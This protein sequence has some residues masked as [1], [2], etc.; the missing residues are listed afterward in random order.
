VYLCYLIGFQLLQVRLIGKI[1]SQGYGWNAAVIYGHQWWRLITPMFLHF[2]FQHVLFNCFSIFLFAPVLEMMLGKWKFSIAYFGSGII[3][4]VLALYFGGVGQL[5]YL[6]ASAAIFGL[7]GIF[8][9]IIIF[10][11]NLMDRQSKQIVAIILI[12]NVAWTFIFPSVDVLGHLFG[13][14]GGFLLGPFLVMRTRDF[15]YREH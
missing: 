8:L 12:A 10:R 3:S 4:N 7:F 15:W 6:G 11:R 1:L 14:L 13:L 5:P 9:F 2:Q